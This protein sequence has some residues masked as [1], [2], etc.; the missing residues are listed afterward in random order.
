MY[1]LWVATFLAC[2]PE[3]QDDLLAAARHLD[4]N[5]KEI[6]KSGKIIGAERCAIMAA[7]NITNE[8][9]QLQRANVQQ[10]ELQD[11]LNNLHSR[12]DEALQDTEPRNEL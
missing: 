1:Q 12:I 3:E 11:R 9:L 6:Q 7:L 10:K 2:P 8:M 5:M 4:G